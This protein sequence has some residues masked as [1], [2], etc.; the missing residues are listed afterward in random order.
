MMD[1]DRKSA[2][3]LQDM[4]QTQQQIPSGKTKK[5]KLGGNIGNNPAFG[6]IT[7]VMSKKNKMSIS[8]HVA[9]DLNDDE[10]E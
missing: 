2:S 8:K 1:F 10:L 4:S 3:S 9:P 7:D 5:K 6:N